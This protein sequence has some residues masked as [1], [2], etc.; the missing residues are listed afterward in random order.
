MHSY[1]NLKVKVSTAFRLPSE[2]LW[3]L[4]LNMKIVRQYQRKEQI[5]SKK[6]PEWRIPTALSTCAGTP[7]I[8]VQQTTWNLS[9]TNKYKCWSSQNK[10]IYK[11]CHY[12]WK[13]MKIY[14]NQSKSH[15]FCKYNQLT[16]NPYYETRANYQFTT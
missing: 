4:V 14:F 5:S 13:Y 8:R 3:K 16:N 12:Y 2:A 9:H 1:V 6:P 11:L 15:Y 7:V 10:E